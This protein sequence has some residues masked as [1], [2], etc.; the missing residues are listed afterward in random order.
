VAKTVNHLTIW[1]H[2]LQAA[3]K[4][5]ARCGYAATSVPHIVDVAGISKPALYY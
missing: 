4:S 2:I 1:Q 3:L 5:F